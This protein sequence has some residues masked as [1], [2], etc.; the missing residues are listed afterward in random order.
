MSSC[1]PA[2]PEYEGIPLDAFFFVPNFVGF[3]AKPARVTE[4]EEL[5]VFSLSELDTI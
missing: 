1:I 4:D 5:L 2:V 3:P